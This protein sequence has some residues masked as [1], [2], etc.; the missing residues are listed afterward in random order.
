MNRLHWP[1]RRLAPKAPAY[2]TRLSKP[3]PAADTAVPVPIIADEIT[4]GSDP[5]QASISLNDLSVDLLHARLVRKEDGSFWLNDEGSVA[6]TWINYTMVTRD[7]AAVE[8]GDLIHIGRIG[9][10]FTHRDLRFQRKP[11]ITLE[12]LPK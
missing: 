6:G 8:H 10:R 4:F 2:L 7:G 11:V 9:F 1:Q 3:G 5:K 12:E